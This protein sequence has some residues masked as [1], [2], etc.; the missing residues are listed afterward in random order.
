M[1]TF[2]LNETAQHALRSVNELSTLKE[3][4]LKGL[5]MVTVRPDNSI[6]LTDEQ[7]IYSLDTS[8]LAGNIPLNR[9]EMKARI[10]VT[11]T[12]PISA[13]D[14]AYDGTA[15]FMI[16]DTATRNAS[17]YLMSAA[18]GG[19][20]SFVCN[21]MFS[22]ISLS[23]KQVQFVQESRDPSKVEILS[24]LYQEENLKQSGIYLDDTYGG[25]DNKAAG[26][27]ELQSLYDPVGGQ[28]HYARGCDPDSIM[29]RNRF[30]KQNTNNQYIRLRSNAFY[31]GAN[32]TGTLVPSE[33]VMTEPYF[34]LNKNNSSF[35]QASGTAASQ[36]IEY[37]VVEDLCHDILV[38]KYQKNPV[39]A[40]IPATDIVF[41]FTKST[42]INSL[43]KTSNTAIT[44]I[45][46]EIVDLELKVLTFN[47]GILD[48]PDNRPYY[49]PFFSE[50]VNQETLNLSTVDQVIDRQTQTR[51]YN[52]VP[53]YVAIWC[54]EPSSSAGTLQNRSSNFNPAKVTSLKLQIDNDI[55]TPLYNLS[56]DELKFRTLTNMADAGW[57]VDSLLR[58][59]PLN[60]SGLQAWFAA[61]GG[62][63]GAAAYTA[64]N[65]IL[66]R[67]AITANRSLLDG[68]FL[69]KVDKDIRLPPNLCV[70]L[71]VKI[72]FT[73]TVSF[74]TLSNGAYMNG[75]T[76]CIFYSYAFF[77]SVYKVSA[78]KGLLEASKSIMT[79]DAMKMLA[80][81]SNSVIRSDKLA[82][83]HKYSSTNPILI[84]SGF[85]Q[86]VDL[87][88]KHFPLAR[89]IVHGVSG[90]AADIADEFEGDIASA[91]AKGARTVKAATKKTSSNKK[92]GRKTK[93]LRLM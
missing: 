91:I 40:G 4:G 80:A 64:A 63:S 41:T 18:N 29:D 70:G 85:G 89:K 59:M 69:L 38:T 35:F 47:F 1:T 54:Q 27:F 65:K 20:D 48:I 76:N 86:I 16:E 36:V 13:Q 58:N 60:T 26:Q 25:Y 73:W 5:N 77:P 51:Q 23:D 81:E 10:R 3:Y 66:G 44:N 57:N 50:V 61:N 24:R 2:V 12:G 30:W 32:G 22:N 15:P 52:S 37:D 19:L 28:V 90:L 68:F 79:P 53:E 55:Q 43:Y 6:G 21:K 33:A 46:V 9:I 67:S 7:Y 45:K 17:N 74:D 8:K 84:G 56:I 93:M 78:E 11:A 34:S 31:T 14:Q 42:L 83:S 62:V 82:N 39:H 75:N 87:A 49:I 72:N 92:P 88:K 71:D